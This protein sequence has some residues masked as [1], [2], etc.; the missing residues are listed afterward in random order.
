[1]S[2]TPTTDVPLI[3][4]LA[5][6]QW[7]Q[8]LAPNPRLANPIDSTT[9]TLQFTAPPLD[10]DGAVITRAFLMGIR[11]ETSYVET[12]YVPADALSEDGLTATG[13][14]RGIY[15]EGLDFTSGNAD[16]ASDF[17]QN[18]SVFCNISG[19]LGAIYQAGLTAQIG[20]NIKLNGRNLFQDD[21]VIAFRVFADAAARDAAIVS[22]QNG[23]TCY[24]TS[25][26]LAQIYQGGSWQDV[27]SGATPNASTSV[28]GKVQIPTQGE[29]NAGTDVGGTGALLT[30]T[31]SVIQT[32]IAAN[33]IR[34]DIFSAKGQILSAS[35]SSTP[36]VVAAGTYGQVPTADA[37]QTSGLIM[38]GVSS[39]IATVAADISLPA[40]SDTVPYSGTIKGGTLGTNNVIRV[41]GL[42]SMSP[43]INSAQPYS[44]TCTYGT[45][46]ATFQLQTFNTASSTQYGSFEFLVMG[47]GST[48]SQYLTAFGTS[49]A[50]FNLSSSINL[51]IAATASFTS[52]IDS[53]V[54]QTLTVTITT[55][56]S[57]GTVYGVTVERIA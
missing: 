18:S 5:V 20:A 21:G 17:N 56:G 34:K 39:K 9:T 13:V 8:L 10:H 1:M 52:A 25:T 31:P 12:V 32:G 33:Y 54:D 3:A 14:T 4:D 37:T 48:N 46:G 16:L 15:L 6:F 29:F 28:A 47:A 7:S 26:G 53:T 45:G 51:G 2:Y 35:A 38:K 24:L 55:V 11:S 42:F 40:A 41:R 44:I 43:T 49:A 22:P 27:A 57:A 50:A 23:D 36:V 19:V 30:P